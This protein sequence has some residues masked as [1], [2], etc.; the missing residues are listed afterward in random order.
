MLRLKYKFLLVLALIAAGALSGWTA[1]P[2]LAATQ[3]GGTPILDAFN[4]ANETPLSGGG[5]WSALSNGGAQ[6]LNNAV[7]SVRGRP[8]PAGR[9]RTP[10]TSKRALPSCYRPTTPG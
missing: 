10:E 3:P 9:T 5:N 2:A 8:H 7:A 1:A 6:L 4:R